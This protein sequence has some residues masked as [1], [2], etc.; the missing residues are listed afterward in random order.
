[1]STGIQTAVGKFVWHENNSTDAKKAQDFYTQLLGWDI[2]V[3]KPGEM[4]YGMIKA[5]GQTHGGFG[6]AQGGAPSHWIGHVLVEDL[7]ETL[8][9]IEAAGGKIVAG[10]MDIPDVGRMAIITDPQGAVLS[11]F[12]PASDEMPVSEGTFVWDELHTSD[13]DGAKSFYGEVFGWTAQDRDMGPM[14]YTMFKRAGDVDVAG[15]MAL[16]EGMQAPPHW[17]P[18]IYANDIDATTAKAKELGATIFVEPA[19]IPDVGR[20]SVLQDPVGAIFGLFRP[21]AT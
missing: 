18:Y 19:D 20:F 12:Q 6:T 7:D 4:D 11:A 2:E 14:T 17:L 3:F 9:R 10:P 21:N 15:C 16:E 8:R 1:M 5:G 13:V